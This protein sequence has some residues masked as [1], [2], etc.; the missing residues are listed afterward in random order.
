MEFIFIFYFALRFKIFSEN[1]RKPINKKIKGLSIKFL[2]CVDAGKKDGQTLMVK[3][4]GK[5]M[6]HQ[7]SASEGQWKQIGEVVGSSGGTQQS[8]GKVL[9][10]GKVRGQGWSGVMKGP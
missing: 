10:E 1:L 2:F 9:Y 5:I 7:W 4:G 8:S 6:A 3:D